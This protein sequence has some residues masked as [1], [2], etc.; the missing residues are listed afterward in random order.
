MSTLDSP[1]TTSR[2]LSSALHQAGT[3][4][5]GEIVAVEI[6][7]RVQSKVSHLWFLEVEYAANSTPDLP[8]RLLLKWPI[9][10]SP[11]PERGVPELVFYRDLAPALPSPPLVRCLATA[12]PNSAHPWLIIEDLRATHTNPPWP[13]RPA[14]HLYDA[15]RV[16]AQ[17]HSHW[18]EA[19]TPFSTVGSLNTET[20]LRTMVGG[21]SAHLPGLIKEEG[22]NLAH[23]DR[24]LLE[25]VFSSSLAPW[26]RLIDPRALTVVN[27]DAHL[28]N[29][30][31]PRS[32]EGATYLIDW[33]FWHLDV[34]VRDVAFLFALHWDPTERRQLE[35]PLLHFY[36]EQLINAGINN[37]SFDDL[38]LD[39][40]RCLVRNLTIPIIRW[41][42]GLARE[43]WR[44]NL[45][46]ALA[47]Y[48]DLNCAE[49]L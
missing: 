24:S 21:I 35:L 26:F 30:L 27:G 4:R 20:G 44:N 3:L 17:I 47:A 2:E 41:S 14:K 38:W 23:A 43:L 12:P 25:T 28:W 8:N 42:T 29:F 1:P 34:G 18:W 31:F 10:Q 16:L 15:V 46:C 9:D 33:Q 6:T 48:R 7:N 39:Y 36:H 32:D 49:L 22:E 45:D 37:Y 40:R 13:E 5:E 19:T 11:A